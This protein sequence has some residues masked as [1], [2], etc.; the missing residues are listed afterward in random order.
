MTTLVTGPAGYV[1]SQKYAEAGT[2]GSAVAQRRRA[3]LKR[4]LSARL[5]RQFGDEPMARSL[6]E[7]EVDKYLRSGHL[8]NNDL[9]ALE[10]SVKQ[11]RP[12]HRATAT[13]LYRPTSGPRLGFCS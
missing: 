9:E 3:E 11:V 8:T 12:G 4:M 13:A 2:A 6:I 7:L 10:H 5:A 1:E